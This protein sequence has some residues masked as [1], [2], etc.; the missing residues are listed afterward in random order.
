MDEIPL[1]NRRAL[2]KQTETNV[3]VQWAKMMFSAQSKNSPMRQF[4]EMMEVP[5]AFLKQQH[6][7]GRYKPDIVVGI[8]IHFKLLKKKKNKINKWKKR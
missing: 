5:F 8:N 7:K 6:E 3:A 4:L 2:S 1:E